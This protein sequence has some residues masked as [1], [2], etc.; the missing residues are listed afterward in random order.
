MEL[1]GKDIKMEDRIKEVL[2]QTPFW[3]HLTK[4]QQERVCRDSREVH[5]P[6][7]SLIYSPTRECLGTVFILKGVIRAYLLS[8]EGKEVTI[9]RIREGDTCV[10]TASCALSAITFDVEIEAETDCEVL[11][12]PAPVFSV[13]AADNIYVENYAYKIATERF[14]SVVEALQQIMFMSLTQRIAAFLIDES[15]QR[16]N[17][18]IHMTHEEIAKAIGSAREAVSRTLK[19]MVKKGDISLFRGGIKI[20]NKSSL[21]ELLP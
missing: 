3:E 6:A 4:E 2:E 12:I 9:Y 5:Y 21:Y 8:D 18:S 16:K 1:Q 15:A 7:G 17:D 10:L 13:L 20:E 19:Q 11:L 14:S